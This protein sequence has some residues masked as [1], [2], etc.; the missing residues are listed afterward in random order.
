MGY[1]VD[2]V[3]VTVDVVN[4]DPPESILEWEHLSGD[5]NRNDEPS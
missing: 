1:I 2:A 4:G 5:S 3:K